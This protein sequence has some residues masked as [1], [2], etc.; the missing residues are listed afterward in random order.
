M[1]DKERLRILLCQP[2]FFYLCYTGRIRIHNSPVLFF[3]V[4]KEDLKEFFG[5]THIFLLGGRGGGGGGS[6]KWNKK[7]SSVV[8][9]FF[10]ASSLKKQSVG[11]NFTPLGH[12]ILIPSQPIFTLAP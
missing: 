9:V 1:S 12:I 8:I 2:S 11:S 3:F 10:I 6:D 4:R 7:K 5:C